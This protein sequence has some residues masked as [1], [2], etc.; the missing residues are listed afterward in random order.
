MP[1]K[2]HYRWYI[3][4]LAALT[5]ALVIAAPSMCLS[6]LFDEISDDLGLS[7]FQ[8]GIIW[9]IGALPAIISM[10]LGGVIGD[11]IGPKR[12]LTVV[13]VLAGSI[14]ALR[15]L[16]P[17]FI[18]LTATILGYSFVATMIP[19]SALKT[20]G[21][22]FPKNQLGLAAGV[23]S[24]G[25]AL[26]FM[27]G[28]MLSATLLSPWLGGWRNVLIFYGLLGMTL[29]IP[30]YFSRPAP[31]PVG[32]TANP[33]GL[34]SL[35]TTMSYVVHIRKMWLLGGAILGIGGCIQGVL[36]YLPLYLRDMGWA[37]ANADGALTAFHTAS[38][39][40]VIPI[41]LWSDRHGTRR[42]VLLVAA[43]MITVGLGLLSVV[44]GFMVWGAVI[45]AGMVRD[46]FMAVFLTM[47]IETDG[48]GP[49]YA[50]TAIG[51]VMI[52]SGV[53]NLLAPPLGNSLANITP[54]LP[55]VFWALMA[56]GGLFCLTLTTDRQP[57]PVV[58]A[59]PST[60]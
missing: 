1:S 39:I 20:C 3:L 15:G 49:A 46:G 56:A 19:M 16:A 5:N 26:G 17:G 6:V 21:L 4:I 27:A 28:S 18:A 14:G 9:G 25:M 43:L 50:G 53:G 60:L 47:I 24:M 40:C 59:A 52:F 45:L 41:A 57:E 55:F 10:L 54:G 35:K 36:G 32:Q 42:K 22:W 34:K 37:A 7:T 2:I 51:F 8:V 31:I 33:T 23:V 13:C 30:W 58:T 12:L 38:M 11:Q 29:S 48:V 44:D